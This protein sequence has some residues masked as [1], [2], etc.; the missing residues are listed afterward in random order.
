MKTQIKQ[1]VNHLG[2]WRYNPFGSE[3]FEGKFYG[4]RSVDIKG[5]LAAINFSGHIVKQLGL[6][7][8]K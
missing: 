8:S 1:T 7:Q 4:R 2:E 3:I 6:Q 5:A